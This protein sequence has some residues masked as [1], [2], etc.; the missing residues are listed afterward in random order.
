[1]PDRDIENLPTPPSGIFII[2]QKIGFPV[3]LIRN[4]CFSSLSWGARTVVDTN[5]FRDEWLKEGGVERVATHMRL[6]LKCTDSAYG[7][8]PGADE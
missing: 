1:M 3:Y 6:F 8:K 2:K 7:K 4:S 5:H